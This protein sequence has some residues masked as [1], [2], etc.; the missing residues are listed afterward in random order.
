MKRKKLSPVLASPEWCIGRSDE[1]G[2]TQTR[3]GTVGVGTVQSSKRRSRSTDPHALLL[4]V[5]K[6]HTVR[7]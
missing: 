6:I 5:P 7:I 3:T 2:T 1:K 4:L